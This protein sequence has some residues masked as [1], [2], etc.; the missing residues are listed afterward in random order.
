MIDA[1]GYDGSSWDTF[2]CGFSRLADLP[3]FTDF[4]VLARDFVL[5]YTIVTY[6]CGHA[7]A[8]KMIDLGVR[9]HVAKPSDPI[10][11]WWMG[12]KETRQ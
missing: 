5:I 1:T 3:G 2:F 8:R 12:T 11:N 9:I 7:T 4:A 10:F 6:V